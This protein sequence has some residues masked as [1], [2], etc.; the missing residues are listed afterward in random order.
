MR[1]ERS[2]T[3]NVGTSLDLASRAIH[4]QTSPHV[5]IG[6]M[7]IGGFLLHADEAP[8]L[9]DF[10]QVAIQIAEAFVHHRLSALAHADA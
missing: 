10:D 6:Q 4:V 1:L 9:I 7:I 2:P 8:N 3:A 5:G